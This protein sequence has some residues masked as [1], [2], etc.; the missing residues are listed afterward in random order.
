MIRPPPSPIKPPYRPAYYWIISKDGFLR[1]VW[2]ERHKANYVDEIPERVRDIVVLAGP[3]FDPTEDDI[4]RWQADPVMRERHLHAMEQKEKQDWQWDQGYYW[5]W[6]RR[7]Q[8]MIALCY[9][10][11]IPVRYSSDE[12]D[13]TISDLHNLDGIVLYG[14]LEEPGMSD[15]MESFRFVP[16]WAQDDDSAS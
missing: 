8:P 7:Y 14:P 15:E 9:E 10:S 4:A 3:I 12:I 2:I 16:P 11:W 6:P 5:I 13:T 1:L